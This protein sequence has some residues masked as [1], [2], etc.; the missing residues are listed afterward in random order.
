MSNILSNNFGRSIDFSSADSDSE[1]SPPLLVDGFSLRSSSST[2]SPR[3]LNFD[4]SPT[5]T[6]PF[7]S[8]KRGRSVEEKKIENF[9]ST[10]E[11]RAN[12]PLNE[13]HS[14]TLESISPNFS[15][16]PDNSKT[17][18]T[19]KS[20]SRENFE[21]SKNDSTDFFNLLPMKNREEFET[22][23]KNSS[24]ELNLA[25]EPLPLNF[26]QI[27]SSKPQRGKRKRKNSENEKMN[28]MEKSSKSKI[29]ELISESSIEKLENSPLPSRKR[30][31]FDFVGS[32]A[33]KVQSPHRITNLHLKSLHDER[34]KRIS[35]LLSPNSMVNSPKVEM[36]NSKFSNRSSEDRSFFSRFHLSELEESKSSWAAPPEPTME[37]SSQTRNYSNASV[38]ATAMFD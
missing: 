8:P 11:S 34:K 30:K 38:N 19:G 4:F 16:F 17:R 24:N 3:E 29:S 26:D 36:K 22:F 18:R 20:P 6:A 27:N 2:P 10:D 25:I 5:N 9:H 15:I 35:L 12:S 13:F 23:I 33:K 21:S 14:T 37:L 31:N 32:L 1:P 28:Q 7:N